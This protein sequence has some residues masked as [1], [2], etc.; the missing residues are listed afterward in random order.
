MNLK[1]LRSDD[2]AVSPVIGVI[3]MVAITVI[4]AAVIG[5]FVLN[6]GNQVQSSAPTASFSFDQVNDTAVEVTH[7]GGDTILHNN[8]GVTVNGKNAYTSGNNTFWNSGGNVSAGTSKMI[9]S[10]NHG[11][12]NELTSGDTIRVVWTS[13]SGENSQVLA[14]Y[15]MS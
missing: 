11:S 14:E 5:T 15:T 1:N 13:D 8:I 2:S 9:E 4:L 3:L 12:G 6:L 7:D 10:Y